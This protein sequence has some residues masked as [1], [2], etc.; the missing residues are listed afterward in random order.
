MIS[1]RFSRVRRDDMFAK[2]RFRYTF[3]YSTR[4]RESGS[5]RHPLRWNKL[6]AGVFCLILILLGGKTISEEN[7]SSQLINQ[8]ADIT[9]D[10]ATPQERISFELKG[11]MPIRYSAGMLPP[12]EPGG[13]HYF[14]LHIKDA[15]TVIN[16][17]R[18]FSRQLESPFV[19]RIRI[20]QYKL[21]PPRV[22]V[23]FSVPDSTT[24]PLIEEQANSLH[25]V[26]EQS[27]FGSIATL[28]VAP[29]SNKKTPMSPQ[30]VKTSK[31]Q[32]EEQPS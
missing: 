18:A 7:D 5:S 12:V 3:G 25:I 32:R 15:H 20:A 9:I 2:Q 8:I 14:Y 1:H 31:P 13:P 17:G 29:A 28:E 23:V 30:Q 10:N 19:T 27:N 6:L 21:E 4:R 22:R 11:A 16:K 24:I 26:F